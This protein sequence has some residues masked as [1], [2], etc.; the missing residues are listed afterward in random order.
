MTTLIKNTA[1]TCNAVLASYNLGGGNTSELAKQFDFTSDDVLVNSLTG[2]SYTIDL[3]V[4]Q[5]IAIHNLYKSDTNLEYAS[6]GY[7]G[8]K[9]YDAVNRA[10]K[11]SATKNPLKQVG[12]ILSSRDYT[13]NCVN[14]N[15]LTADKEVVLNA[16][17]SMTSVIER[18][19]NKKVKSELLAPFDA[20][21]G[22]FLTE[23]NTIEA[24]IIADNEAKDLERFDA[25]SSA[26]FMDLSR[27]TDGTFN[28]S[29]D[30][31]HLGSMQSTLS[32]ND[33][34]LVSSSFNSYTNQIDIVFSEDTND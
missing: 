11:T 13:E 31:S 18:I 14:I 8:K 24:A 29:I 4:L 26:G 23:E 3:P 25:L 12:K 9:H 33:L 17:M 34:I 19:E 16:L 20:L 7:L 6:F 1:S 15:K 32:T 10:D 28:A 22:Q 5:A 30:G 21:F 27:N 2:E